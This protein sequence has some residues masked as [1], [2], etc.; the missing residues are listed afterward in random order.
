MSLKSESELYSSDFLQFDELSSVVA[1]VAKISTKYS[2]LV[3]LLS[4]LVNVS[5]R[6]NRLLMLARRGD[7][8]LMLAFRIGLQVFLTGVDGERDIFSGSLFRRRGF[9]RADKRAKS[10]ARCCLLPFFESNS[11][12]LDVVFFGVGEA[13]LLGIGEALLLWTGEV[14]RLATG[15]DELTDLFI[16]GVGVLLMDG[17][18]GLL[19]DGEVSLL[20]IIFFC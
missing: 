5:G 19:G 16:T 13:L 8:D 1:V 2:L 20:F 9:A 10:G 12:S 3:L 15:D 17:E 18:D 6:V 7:L 4:R 11:A 14:V